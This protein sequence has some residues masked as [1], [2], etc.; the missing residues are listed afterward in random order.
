MYF[1]L[2]KPRGHLL[3]KL[4]DKPFGQLKPN[5][6]P[7]SGKGQRWFNFFDGLSRSK[8]IITSDHRMKNSNTFSMKADEISRVCLLHPFYKSFKEFSEIEATAATTASKV[9]Y[10]S[11]FL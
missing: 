5:D 10:L 8:H 9:N 4:L 7:Q 3:D 6:F 11:A 2:Y 1:N